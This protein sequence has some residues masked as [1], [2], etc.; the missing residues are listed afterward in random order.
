MNLIA[1]FNNYWK[2][3]L[4]LLIL[5]IYILFPLFT[6]YTFL[7]TFIINSFLNTNY[8]SYFNFYDYG[9]SLDTYRDFLKSKFYVKEF[10]LENSNPFYSYDE[11]LGLFIHGDGI[12]KYF[13]VINISFIFFENF[14]TGYDFTIA[15]SITLI[16]ISSFYFSLYF[17]NNFF[18][19]SLLTLSICFSQTILGFIPKTIYVTS[20]I[21]IILNLAF[22]LRLVDTKKTRFYFYIFFIN[23]Y[24]ILNGS[25]DLLLFYYASIF[26]FL[27]YLLIFNKFKL[28]NFLKLIFAY[29]MSGVLNTYEIIAFL[30]FYNSSDRVKDIKTS[31]ESLYIEY[32][33]SFFSFQ[34]I[35]SNFSNSIKALIEIKNDYLWYL[36]PIYR[37]QDSY[38][39][40]GP[41]II[42]SI[43]ALFS[44][45]NQ[46]NNIHKFIFLIFLIVSL[47]PNLNYILN[48]IDAF[49]FLRAGYKF[50]WAVHIFGFVILAYYL[51]DTDKFFY[52][53]KFH[54]NCMN[55]TYILIFILNFYFILVFYLYFNSS[56][57]DLKY[58][59]N[60]F[61]YEKINFLRV[62]LFSIP[63][64]L[65]YF[66]IN[67]NGLKIKFIFFTIALWSV[68]QLFINLPYFNSV[69]IKQLND[70]KEIIGSKYKNQ[71]GTILTDISYWD[72][73]FLISDTIDLQYPDNLPGIN[74]LFD[75]ND[76]RVFQ[77]S[78]SKFHSKIC[79]ELNQ[80]VNNK[81]E[82]SSFILLDL[83]INTDELCKYGLDFVLVSNKYVNHPNIKNSFNK[84]YN[85]S[86]YLIKELDC[87]YDD[88]K[89]YKIFN[90]KDGTS[91]F[92]PKKNK[93][94]NLINSEFIFDDNYTIDLGF[95]YND[96]FTFTINN[97]KISKLTNQIKIQKG[98]I[99]KIEYYK[100]SS[101]FFW[102]PP[103]IYILFFFF[104]F[105][106]K[107]KI[108]EKFW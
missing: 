20:F 45:K 60:N 30:E 58:L 24:G 74:Y 102:L 64:L 23:Y 53:K 107:F 10:Y 6:D 87:S 91:L 105:Y 1:F 78:L 3:N 82:C 25:L 103:V 106:F 81:S 68:L 22:L 93:N 48:N 70:F 37:G 39:G 92:I 67:K 89:N 99:L 17:T 14:L 18:V 69:S 36:F 66:F 73:R 72:K 47:T 28:D 4:L 79:K 42:F 7:P 8:E 59:L 56:Q 94:N 61:Y 104:I 101:V 85:E 16:L 65:T 46:N 2:F 15:L 98:D 63:L 57:Y 40:I 5:F 52:E 38:I 33:I 51:K 34:S 21:T 43:G 12:T 62:F 88:K 95:Y 86:P 71:N 96:N 54:K 75:I 44:F 41:I 55:I 19:I 13:D 11:G 50:Y 31:Y 27:L 100:N 80:N 77:P 76:I 29:L 9:H 26:I 108:R 49:K 32:L 84:I 35:S 83:E 90:K 97:S